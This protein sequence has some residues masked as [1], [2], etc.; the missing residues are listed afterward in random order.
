MA[1]NLSTRS[2]VV[3]KNCKYSVAFVHNKISAKVWQAIGVQE[4]Q[5]SCILL[6]K[7]NKL[8]VKVTTQQVCSFS[9]R[10]IMCKEYVA[11]V[12]EVARYVYNSVI[13][14]HLS[15]SLQT[16]KIANVVAFVHGYVNFIARWCGIGRE[17]LLD[18]L[19]CLWIANGVAFVHRNTNF[20][21]ILNFLCK[22]WCDLKIS[23]LI[24]SPWSQF[25]D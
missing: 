17:H 25:A 1:W 15:V 19:S 9:A 18:I 20:V 16:Y 21:Q 22:F 24:W 7:D 14:R 8:H 2:Q 13:V 11:F 5:I 6:C 4:M 3:I 23:S 12:H 10:L